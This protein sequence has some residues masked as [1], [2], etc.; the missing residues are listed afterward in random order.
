MQGAGAPAHTSCPQRVRRTACG[1]PPRGLLA[2]NGSSEGAT[3]NTSDK[4]SGKRPKASRQRHDRLEAIH[5]QCAQHGGVPNRGADHADRAAAAPHA[6]ARCRGRHSVGVGRRTQWLRLVHGPGD[7]VGKTGPA[8]M[9]RWLAR[10]RC[11]QSSRMMGSRRTSRWCAPHSR[12]SSGRLE[13]EGRQQSHLS[14]D[15]LDLVISS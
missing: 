8:V 5:Q 2:G 9:A 1:R 14:N 12:R 11:T 13:E 15:E 3:T 4:H 7:L 10:S 6:W